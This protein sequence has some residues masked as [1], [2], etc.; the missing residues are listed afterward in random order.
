MRADSGPGR[1][2][3][4][5]ATNGRTCASVR[6][7]IEQRGGKLHVTSDELGLVAGRERRTGTTLS[8]EI[9]F[10]NFLQ[11]RGV[12]PGLN[13]LTLEVDRAG[14]AL[15]ESVEILDDSGIER[16]TLGPAAVKLSLHLPDRD[17]RVGERFALQ[18]ELRNAGETVV[19]RA[20]VQIN[21]GRGLEALGPAQKAITWPPTAKATGEFSLRAL[22]PGRLPLEVSAAAAGSLPV[23][24]LR[25]PVAA[26]DSGVSRLWLVAGVALV[27]LAAALGSVVLRRRRA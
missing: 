24:S 25:V 18:F 20:T 17:I 5:A 14:A 22:E 15:A 7:T 3:V 9:D 1:I 23:A 27:L 11:Y 6:L 26:A 4:V 21:L 8:R 2:Y 12:R 10:S 13:E 19:P 16:S